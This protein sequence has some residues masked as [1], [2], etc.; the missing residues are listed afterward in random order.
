[1]HAGLLTL[2]NYFFQLIIFFQSEGDCNLIE[3]V[4]RQDVVEITNTADD[5]HSLVGGT[6]GNIVIQYP[7]HIVSPL[8]ILLNSVDILL[9]R[10]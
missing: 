2:R 8:R 1:M 5:L 3:T 10:S 6:S 7:S 9:C 4:L